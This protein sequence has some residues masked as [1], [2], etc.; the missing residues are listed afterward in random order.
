[1]LEGRIDTR[2]AALDIALRKGQTW[3]LPLAI[4][5]DLTGAF[6]FA[7]IFDFAGATVQAIAVDVTD[8]VNGLATLSLT[9]VQ[10]RALL[11]SHVAGMGEDT[12]LNWG[13]TLVDSLGART[14][15]LGG[16]VCVSG[17]LNPP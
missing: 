15:L 7:R 2:G 10:T 3:A 13:V 12:S 11:P 14:P 9:A 16:K 1:M 4:E 5:A 8:A 17:E 6:V